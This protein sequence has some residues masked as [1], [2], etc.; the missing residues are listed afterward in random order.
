MDYVQQHERTWGTETYP[1]RPDLA[2][3]LES[4]VVVFWQV[5]GKNEKRAIVSLHQDLTEIEQYFYKLIFRSSVDQPKQRVVVI[6]RDKKRILVK[7]VKIE[8]MEAD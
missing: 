7:T 3:I 1:S 5:E 6:F 2:A 8:F 4:P